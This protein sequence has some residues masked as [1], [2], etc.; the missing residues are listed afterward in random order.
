MHT[1]PACPPSHAAS[2]P[3]PWIARF[4]A[5]I[6]PGAWLTAPL[7]ARVAHA[8]SP[9]ALS[10]AFGLFLLAVAGRMLYRSFMS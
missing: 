8:L 7:G 4:A 1:P 10:L 2:A 3:S 6:A 9:R 5:L